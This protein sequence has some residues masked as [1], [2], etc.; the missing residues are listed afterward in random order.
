METQTLLVFDQSIATETR[1]ATAIGTEKC[2]CNFIRPLLSRSGLFS[3]AFNSL[4][5][6]VPLFHNR[7][8]MGD[9]TGNDMGQ[10]AH[11]KRFFISNASS[12]PLFVRQI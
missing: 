2:R 12:R 9:M 4:L 7:C 5:R 10:G 11:G 6:E 1:T 8:V 3:I